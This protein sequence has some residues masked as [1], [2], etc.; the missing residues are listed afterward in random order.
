M[1]KTRRSRVAKHIR[2]VENI[3]YMTALK[4]VT[5]LM[6]ENPV[7]F[8]TMKTEWDGDYCAFFHDLWKRRFGDDYEEMS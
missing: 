6:E 8:V 1:S 4:D 5:L 2:D 7:W 3:K